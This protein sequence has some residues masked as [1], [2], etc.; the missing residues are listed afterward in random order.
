M[1]LGTTYLENWGRQDKIQ[2]QTE[3]MGLVRELGEAFM[4][5]KFPGSASCRRPDLDVTAFVIRGHL[6][7][8]VC[9]HRGY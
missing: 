8:G 6:L 4:D 2:D 7:Q 1:N 9:V 3:K 5:T